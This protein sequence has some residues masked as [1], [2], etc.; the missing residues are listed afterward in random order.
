MGDQFADRV[1]GKGAANDCSRA[2][3]MKQDLTPEAPRWLHALSSRSRP[4]R[5]ARWP[6]ELFFDDILQD[7]V[8]QRQ[9]SVHLLQAPILGLELLESAQVRRFQPAVLR[10]PL[11]ERRVTDAQLSA[12]VLHRDTLLGPLQGADDLLFTVL[13]LAQDDLLVKT[14]IM[15]KFQLS[16][17]R[18]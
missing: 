11:V 2:Q 5:D 10:P 1:D 12:N 13:A 7:L 16:V 18:F 9:I 8:I 15:S 3:C 4:A 14:A 6:S 17:V